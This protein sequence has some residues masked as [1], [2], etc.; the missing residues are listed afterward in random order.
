MLLV[1]EAGQ[2]YALGHLPTHHLGSENL[3]CSDPG[4][5]RDLGPISATKKSL[6]YSTRD[7]HS[8]S[9]CSSFSCTPALPPK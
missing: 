5:T 7:R 6:S 3:R 4:R 1:K 9:L 2:V 8:E